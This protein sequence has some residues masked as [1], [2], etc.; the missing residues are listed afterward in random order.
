MSAA[1]E[2]NEIEET[3]VEIDNETLMNNVQ[4]YRCIYDKSCVDYKVPQKKRNA[5]QKIAESMKLPVDV[6]QKRYSSIRTVF[7]RYI[8][9]LSV[10]SGSGRDDVP[11]IKPTGCRWWSQT[12]TTIWKPGF[13]GVCDRLGNRVADYRRHLKI[14][15]K[16]AF[17]DRPRQRFKCFHTSGT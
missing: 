15:W 9:S 6:I 12:L 13:S 17:T 1:S 5:W 8:K 3:S 11:N 10:R 14:I 16:P 4:N 7:S 2:T